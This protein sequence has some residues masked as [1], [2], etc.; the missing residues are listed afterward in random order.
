M[1][2]FSCILNFIGAEKAQFL[3]SLGVDHVVD[4]S[5]G[6]VIESV[7]QFLKAIRLKGVD[8]VD[9]YEGLH[10]AS[11]MGSKH[12]GYICTTDK[13]N[14]RLISGWRNSHAPWLTLL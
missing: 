4:L 13:G 6:N 2:I 5:K 8:V 1:V 14:I 3:Q 11:K 12:S 10:E 9:T 7:K